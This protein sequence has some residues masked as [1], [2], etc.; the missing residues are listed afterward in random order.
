MLDAHQLNI[1]LVA[2]ETLNFT[3]AADQ[4]HMSQPSVSQHIR[5]LEKHFDAKLFIRQGRSLSLSDAGR[6]L[7]PLARQFV[8]QSTCIDEAMSSLKGQIQGRI[9]IACN[10]PAGRYILPEFF[11]QFHRQYPEVTIACQTDTC[12]MPYDL[13]QKGA[14]HFV[15]SN[16]PN[17]LTTGVKFQEI[18]TEDICLITAPD[19]PWA[20]QEAVELD[21]LTE[22]IFILPSEGSPT[23]Q[24]INTQL[25][26]HGT[27]LRQLNTFLTLS[28][29]EAI[30]IS[31]EKGL[32]VGFASQVIARH[33]AKVACIPIQGARISRKVTISHDT[34]QP[35]TAARKAFWDFMVN[36]SGKIQL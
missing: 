24:T 23:Y 15:V 27:S 5:A 8:K 35:S 34:N 22:E 10:A 18:F 4:L 20:E 21:Q 7:I 19:H 33:L 30:I 2:A 12:E 9:C 6:T 1:F 25:L 17:G 29:P 26:E 3:R 16:Q 28:N 14:T 13:L 11:A 31:V 32:G 36:L